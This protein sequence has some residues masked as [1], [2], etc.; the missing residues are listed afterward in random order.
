LGDPTLL[1]VVG[2]I[3]LN[4]AVGPIQIGH[5]GLFLAR[6]GFKQLPVDQSAFSYTKFE[7]FGFGS[8][9]HYQ[10]LKP[11]GRGSITYR[12]FCLERI[13]QMDLPA[14]KLDSVEKLEDVAIDIWTN[15]A[16]Q[17]DIL[18][19]IGNRRMLLADS[20]SFEL[21]VSHEPLRA[22]LMLYRPETARIVTVPK[23]GIHNLLGRGM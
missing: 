9:T 5:F 14:F 4:S 8:Q 17:P 6:I 19:P 12:R 15:T 21:V 2:N 11:I 22:E 13:R 1:S 23:H 7:P 20:G 18:V 10:W 16:S 3:I